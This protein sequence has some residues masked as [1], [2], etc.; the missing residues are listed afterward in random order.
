MLFRSLQEYFFD[1][2]SKIKLVL[3]NN[4]MVKTEKL[5]ESLFPGMDGQLIKNLESRNWEINQDLFKKEADIE[6]QIVSLLQ[7]ITGVK[8]KENDL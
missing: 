3:G 2:W 1:D 7:I 4:G 8:A 5:E 6:D